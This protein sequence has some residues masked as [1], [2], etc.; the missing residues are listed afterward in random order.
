MLANQADGMT[1][2]HS[3]S[4]SFLQTSAS[5]QAQSR[6]EG[7]AHTSRSE[8]HQNSQLHYRQWCTQFVRMDRGRRKA[9]ARK[10]LQ[11]LQD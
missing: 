4:I 10:Q 7:S 6:Y 9:R 11:I 8:R 2:L 5:P 3:R 1:I